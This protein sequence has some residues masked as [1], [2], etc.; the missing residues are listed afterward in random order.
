MGAPSVSGGFTTLAGFAPIAV[1]AVGAKAVLK[2]VKK[3]K[4]KR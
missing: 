2:T 4:K 1:T 3:R